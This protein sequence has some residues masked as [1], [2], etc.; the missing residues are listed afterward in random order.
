LALG[1]DLIIVVPI[2]FGGGADHP[3]AGPDHLGADLIMMV[4]AKLGPMKPATGHGTQAEGEG[5][6]EDDAVRRLVEGGR[7]LE[8]A[9]PRPL[10]DMNPR[11]VA[12]LLEM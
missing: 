6:S 4:P 10:P 3:G 12:S 8:V 9:P 7:C 5:G 1:P 11:P 2:I